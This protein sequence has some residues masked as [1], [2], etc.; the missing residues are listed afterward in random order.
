MGAV[1]VYCGAVH[2]GATLCL[3]T[4]V[5]AG[6]TASRGARRGMVRAMQ[7]RTV[8]E[9]SAASDPEYAA[10]EAAVKR[11]GGRCGLA[12]VH[13]RDVHWL[14]LPGAAAAGAGDDVSDSTSSTPLGAAPAQPSPWASAPAGAV[15]V[16]ARQAS[17]AGEAEGS[18][19]RSD[20]LPRH[21]RLLST[22]GG[23]DITGGTAR[24]LGQRLQ[25]GPTDSSLVSRPP[26]AA[27]SQ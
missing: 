14:E 11:L 26:H 15:A 13:G 21:S 16:A 8:R 23:T 19:I 27:G 2:G 24:S 17:A 5:S 18:A 20:Q 22:M 9:V 6:G 10:I 7:R 12:R 4:V 3:A 1:T 25:Q